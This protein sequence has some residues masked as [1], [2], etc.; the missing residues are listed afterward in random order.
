MR[1][2]PRMQYP[3][4]TGAGDSLYWLLAAALFGAQVVFSLRSMN[5]IRYE[6]LMESVRNVY[7]LQY[8][9]VYNGASTNI[10]WYG[11]LLCVYNCIGFGLHTAKIVRLA[12]DCVSIFCLAHVLRN[13]MGAARAWLPLVTVC[14]SP[15][16]LYF[17]MMQGGFG[18][19]LQYLPICLFLATKLDFERKWPVVAL[20]AV[21]WGLVMIACMSYPVFVLYLPVL[22]ILYLRQ[23][24]RGA[25]MRGALCVTGNALVSIAAFMVPL[26]AGF[27]YV[28]NRG[29]LV[30]DPITT[31]GMFRGG[32][33]IYP[34][35]STLV[36]CLKVVF[37]ELFVKGQGYHLELSRTEFSGVTGMV[38]V[39]FVMAAG[40]VL[41][42]T[43]RSFRPILLLC[44]LLLAI[45]CILPNLD[46]TAPGIRRCTGI[47]AALYALYVIVW[48]YLSGRN[49]LPLAC[50]WAG[51]LMC[52]L[53]PAHHLLAYPE[54]LAGLATPSIFRVQVWYEVK[55]TPAESLQFWLHHTEEGKGLL[56]VD[57]FGKPVTR[58]TEIYY[59]LAGYRRWNR[60][61][62]TPL[63]AYDVK[64]G[65]YIPLSRELFA[66]GY[67]Y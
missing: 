26:A 38:P 23:L 63:M 57:G 64:S 17:N 67:I 25:E 54:N 28:K 62:E 34:D 6:E 65:R 44:G 61:K 27:L 16:F 32:G 11:L 42:F 49:A 56:L 29:I 19:D 59:A 24:R 10:G 8:R 47:L 50:K 21:L 46:A 53:L 45:N 55:S 7:L 48:Y 60:L 12:L 58:Y 14:L 40:L 9:T 18:L 1:N 66:W 2:V 41:F 30:Y 39:V 20:Q 5:Q 43:R 31:K 22:I 3:E 15:I 4:K 52:V 37:R 33:N 13:V 51:I 35:L 36:G